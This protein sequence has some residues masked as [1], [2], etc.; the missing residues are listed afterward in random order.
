MFN[1]ATGALLAATA[2]A[3]MADYS[4]NGANWGGLCAEGLEQSPINLVTDTDI[5]DK[6]ELVGYNYYDFASDAKASDPTYTTSFANQALRSQAEL[7]ITFADGSKSFFTPLQFHFHAPSEHSVDGKL[8]DAEVHFVHTIKGSGTTDE[9]GNVS[10]ELLGGVVGVFFDMEEGGSTDNPF[11]TSLF[12]SAGNEN[13]VNIAL[14]NFL[15]G[16]DMTDYWSYDGS[17]TTPPCSEGLKW[18]VIK[19]VQPISAEQLKKFTARMSD[20]EN[21]AGGNGNNRVVQGLNSRTLYYSGAYSMAAYA[22]TALA[23]AATLFF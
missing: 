3:G 16:I 18:S 6:M 21:F 2:F 22:A 14:R 17:L 20:D 8:Y 4:E 5:S 1:Y 15:G 19:Q 11:L 12:E 9:N 10:G 13:E 7:Q 23:A